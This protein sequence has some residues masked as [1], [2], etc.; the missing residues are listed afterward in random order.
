MRSKQLKNGKVA[1]YDGRKRLDDKQ[2]KEH[3]KGLLKAGKKLPKL[4][5]EQEKYV[6]KAKGGLARA[7]DAKT[8]EGGKFV[9]GI[10]E[11][12]TKKLKGLNLQEMAEGMGYK[13][14]QAMLKGNPEIKASLFEAMQNTGL[15]TWFS[16]ENSIDVISDFPGTIILNG[17]AVTKEKAQAAIR[18]MQLQIKNELGNMNDAIKLNFVGTEELKFKLPDKAD[19]NEILE[20]EDLDYSDFEEFSDYYQVYG[21]KEKEA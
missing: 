1:F 5:A 12:A 3:L 20:S 17:K 2:V 21:S 6:A 13:S 4:D 9:D 18:A 11:R 14:P 7:K 15:A 19:L 16:G 8:R 10:I